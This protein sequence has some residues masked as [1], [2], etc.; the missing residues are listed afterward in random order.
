MEDYCASRNQTETFFQ[1]QLSVL[2]CTTTSSSNAALAPQTLASKYIKWASLRLEYYASLSIP[3]SITPL[4][5]NEHRDAHLVRDMRGL[6]F[7]SLLNMFPK[8]AHVHFTWGCKANSSAGVCKPNS[9]CEGLK[10]GRSTKH[11][12]RLEYADAT[13]SAEYPDR[14][15]TLLAEAMFKHHGILF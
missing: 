12:E 15:C 2:I 11:D 7:K 8:L 10:R 4:D 6:D 13:H 5:W 14:L 1:I 3:P 9:P